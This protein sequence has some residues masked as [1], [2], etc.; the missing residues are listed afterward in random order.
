MEFLL[1]FFVGGISIAIFLRCD[2]CLEFVQELWYQTKRM[3]QE[4]WYQTNRMM[5]RIYNHAG[6]MRNP[7][8][9]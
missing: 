8:E 5:K 2:Y 9:K 3:I 6:K 7:F 1:G 4:L